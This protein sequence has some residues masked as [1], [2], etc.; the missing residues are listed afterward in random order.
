MKQLYSSGLILLVL[1]FTA[2]HPKTASTESDEIVG[3][4]RDAHGCIGSA[5]YTWSKLRKECIRPFEVGLQM[6]DVQHVGATGVA[7]LVAVGGNDSKEVF[8][9][10]GG[11]SILLLKKGKKWVDANEEYTLREPMDGSYELYDAEGVLLFKTIK[12]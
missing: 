10:S 11:E 9:P 2:C 5:G 6:T 12:P 7:Y 8:L 3:N 1:L 4:D